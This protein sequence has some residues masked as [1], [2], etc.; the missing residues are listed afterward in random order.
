MSAENTPVNLLG[1]HEGQLR[2]YFASLGEKPFRAQQVM[3][4]IYHQGVTGF[5]DM[6]NL[7]LALREQLAGRAEVRP[8]EI[9]GEQ[10]SA[11]GTVKWLCAGGVG[12]AIETVFIPEPGRGTL[13][14]SSQ[15]GCTLDCVFCQTGLMGFLRNLEAWE[16]VAQ[17]RL[18]RAHAPGPI[19]NDVLMGMGEPLLNLDNVLPAASLM[20]DDFAF[21]L[22]KRRVTLSTAGV[23]PGLRRLAGET[24]ISLLEQVIINL[25]TNAHHAMRDAGS[26][27]GRS[28]TR[29]AKTETMSP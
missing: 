28:K 18:A 15:V 7:S 25:L 22:S 8:P 11:D 27:C 29:T 4:W 14:I 2:G 26:R 17:H 13:C 21:A 19:T 24:D 16:I 12:Q 3:K 6:T 23:V 20:Q 10:V 1:L 5:D 9:V